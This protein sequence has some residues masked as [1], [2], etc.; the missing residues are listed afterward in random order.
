[1]SATNVDRDDFLE[2]EVVEVGKY[3]A[4]QL[5]EIKAATQKEVAHAM[6]NEFD[7]KISEMKAS[8]QK[9][10]FQL[11][12]EHAKKLQTTI[13]AALEDSQKLLTEQKETHEKELKAMRHEKIARHNGDLQKKMEVYMEK[14]RSEHKV[15][16]SI[17]KQWHM[18]EVYG[19]KSFL[20]SQ[21]DHIKRLEERLKVAED[22]KKSLEAPFGAETAKKGS[23]SDK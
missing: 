1:M 17:A 21:E 23:N 13:E 4:A 10:M 12:D 16:T 19:L 20:K 15:S 3:T 2:Y 5:A 6:Q 9:Q 18:T 7:T 22:A 8:H 11:I 14:M